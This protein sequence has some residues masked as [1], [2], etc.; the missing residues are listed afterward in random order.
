MDS[1]AALTAFK[2]KNIKIILKPPKNFVRN[3]VRIFS[4]PGNPAHFLRQD[5]LKAS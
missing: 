4:K 2:D 3:K 1:S 5:I